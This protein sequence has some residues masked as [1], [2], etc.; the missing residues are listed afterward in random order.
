MNFASE[1]ISKYGDHIHQRERMSD[2]PRV[3][4]GVRVRVMVWVTV[5]DP[6]G[7]AVGVTDAVRLELGVAVWEG[8]RVWLA[9]AVGVG[10]ADGVP[11]TVALLVRVPVVV[12]VP[13]GVGLKDVVA[14]VDVGRQS[15]CYEGGGL[16][17]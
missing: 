3:G 14:V 8:L 16:V 6:E 2:A 5:R 10:E 9:V 7:V 1:Q 12:P 13:V 17:L 15:S 11:D 4:D